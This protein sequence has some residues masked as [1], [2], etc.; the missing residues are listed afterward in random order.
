MTNSLLSLV[1]FGGSGLVAI[2][3]L[4]IARLLDQRD[5]DARRRVFELSHPRGED[6]RQVEAVVR[7]VVGL[8]PA[9]TGVRGQ[10]AAVF[11]LVG[12]GRRISYRMRLP[13]SA[14]DYLVGQL[15]AA[16]PGIAVVEL[17]EFVPDKPTYA[18]AL[19]RKVGDGDLNVRDPEATSRAFIAAVSEMRKT[20]TLVWQV[21]V[22]GGVGARPTGGSVVQQLWRGNPKTPRR[23]DTGVV[24]VS[25][26]I[27][28]SASSKKRARELVAR[29]RRAAA[30]TS[31]PGAQMS[32]RLLP[33][34]FLVGVVMRAAT[35]ITAAGVL[36]T[37]EEIAALLGWPMGTPMVVG[38][39][40]GGSP[41]LP[42]PAGVPRHGR[43]L[44][45]SSVDGRRVAQPIA[46]ARTHL[47][48]SG[49]T[50][51]GK[52]WLGIRMF[53]DDVAAGRAALYFDPKGKAANAILSRLSEDAIGRV[54]VIDPT[55]ESRPVP[56][57]LLASEGGIRELAADTV[58]GL[59][60]HRFR[61]LGPRS[62]DII[63]SSLYA[64]SRVPDA[65][66]MDL[67]RL[68]SDAGFRARVAGLVSS[69]PVLA[70][71]FA[72][73]NG[74][75]VAERSFVL[76]PGL[77]KIRPLLQRSVV[78]NV[79][80]APR[81]TFTISQVMRERL[82][83]IVRLPEGVLGPDATTLLAQA[84]LARVWAATQARRGQGLV[85]LIVDEA[86][87]LLDMPTDLAEVLARAREYGLGVTLIG[88]SVTQYPDKLREIALNSARGKVA[89]GT[90]AK[91]ARVLAA[92]FGNG[93]QAD[94]FTG[95]AE[96]EAIGMVGLG[97][98]VSQPFTFKTEALEPPVK[99]RAKAVREA[100]RKRWGVPRKE[101]E[102]SLR[103]NRGNGEDGVGP[104]G[105]RST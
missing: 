1:S 74:L 23:R 2:A 100:S 5:R 65:T 30:S 85:S 48:I 96:F 52:T 45:R 8:A 10:D 49:P 26:R 9:K 62:T 84:L 25:L 98:S 87:R 81:S 101:I 44:G 105:R 104:V 64:L 47:L 39:T 61:D 79:L 60:R 34:R 33:Q 14:A 18:L 89:F 88:Q 50:G 53:I 77:N 102:A 75:S 57:P 66:L 90:S 68:W 20:E 41:Q 46:G 51:S 32:A 17:D 80:A 24:R 6:V 76:A 86:P 21:V 95:L 36:A 91:D 69:E 3:G 7:A 19:R 37:V 56:L 73:F 40:L 38:L 31:A 12:R 55:D 22:M 58:V 83:V 29:L 99:G 16:V 72:W 97:G 28:A 54:I 82:A 103:R 63:T 27:G 43:I 42:V 94:F 59:L 70:T 93:V 78:R 67:L 35:P 92:E 13:A 15:R 71:F 4:I 11:E